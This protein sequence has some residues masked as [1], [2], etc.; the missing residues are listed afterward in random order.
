MIPG[1]HF[2]WRLEGLAQSKIESIRDKTLAALD[3]V[4]IYR[5]DHSCPLVYAHNN[6]GPHEEQINIK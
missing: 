1:T 4:L 2:C 5:H 6:T 3:N